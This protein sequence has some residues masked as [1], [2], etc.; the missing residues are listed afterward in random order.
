MKKTSLHN[1][2]SQTAAVLLSLCLTISGSAVASDSPTPDAIREQ[3]NVA[4]SAALSYIKGAKYNFAHASLTEY[5]VCA[6]TLADEGLLH[7]Y[8]ADTAE[9][10]RD[11]YDY[12][13]TLYA[14]TDKS[15][16][17]MGSDG[18]FAKDANAVRLNVTL[19]YAPLTDYL[20]LIPQT[21]KE[22]CI[23]IALDVESERSMIKL[24]A[25]ELDDSIVSDLRTMAKIEGRVYLAFCPAVN[26]KS[27]SRSLHMSYIAAFRHIAELA[28]RYAPNVQTVYS[29]GD[30]TAAGDDTVSRFYPGDEFV[31]VFGVELTRISQ[32]LHP[33]E[34]EQAWSH[35]GTYYDP[36]YSV[37]RLADDFAAATGRNIPLM[38]TG[39]SFPWD[40]YHARED[41][42]EAMEE[43]YTALPLLRPELVAIFYKNS[44]D[45]YGVC[46]LRQNKTAAELYEKCITLAESAM[47][48]E[49]L[50]SV[51]LGSTCRI[52]VHN[53]R[54]HASP[55]E[56][57]QN[58]SLTDGSITLTEGDHHLEVYLT[59][60]YFYSKLEYIL[61]VRRDGSISAEHVT[62][63]Y[64]YN[65]NG[66]L[67]YGD[68]EMLSAYIA[69]WQVD[70]GGVSTDVNGDGKTNIRDLAALE[71][72]MFP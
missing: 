71:S 59:G 51:T 50:D 36:V 15:S 18:Y 35:T 11:A 58:G 54:L 23:L 49:S 21:S 43:F 16:V 3:M 65:G 70:M 10:L 62:P 1:I 41:W 33:T 27:D 19:G 46:N 22:L 24:A 32:S 56:V 64:D 14:V 52:I 48:L 12:N 8:Y 6:R 17:F 37:V 5:A 34:E 57:Y 53:R 44:S 38:V 40:G 28:R 26:N 69:K 42:A 45:S 2:I 9:S 31:D 66:I 39:C 55:A 29:I 25:G 20:H 4:K 61:T 13:P 47:P 30:K 72:Q 63:Y 68:S 60:D 7:P 67:D